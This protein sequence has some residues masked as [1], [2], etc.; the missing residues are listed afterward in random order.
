MRSA[1]LRSVG[2]RLLTHRGSLA[3][4]IGGENGKRVVVIDERL[5]FS[6]EDYFDT[7][8]DLLRGFKKRDG[9]G[10]ALRS[11]SPEVIMVDEI[12]SEGEAFAMLSYLNSGVKFVATAHADGL[13]MLKRKK[14]LEPLFERG[15]F[16]VFVGLRRFGAS[17]FC[18]VDSGDF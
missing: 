2:R 13:S 7:R 14:N 10:I 4:A 12:G 17:F 9:L 3:K 6:P 16:D 15:V 5:E 8:V 1:L 11:L 18:E